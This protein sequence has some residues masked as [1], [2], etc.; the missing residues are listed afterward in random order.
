MDLYSDI[1]NRSL[2]TFDNLIVCNIQQSCLE[3]K[4]LAKGQTLIETQSKSIQLDD[5]FKDRRM[6]L[7]GFPY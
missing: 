4:Y 3:D 2:D 6:I 5:F 7:K 1:I